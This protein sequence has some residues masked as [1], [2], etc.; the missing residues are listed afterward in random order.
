MEYYLSAGS[1]KRGPYSVAE[2]ATRGIEAETLVMASEGGQWQPAWQVEELRPIIRSQSD[3]I[4]PQPSVETGSYTNRQAEEPVVEGERVSEA[5]EVVQGYAP[6]TSAQPGGGSAVPPTSDRRSHKHFGGCLVAALVALVLLVG[7]LVAT[8][9][10]PEQHAAAVSNVVSGAVGDLLQSDSVSSDN[11]FGAALKSF[12]SGATSQVAGRVVGSAL[13]VDD[14]HVCSIG[15]I[16][17]DGKSHVVSVGVL[18][19][20]FTVGS[21]Y[22]KELANH[23]LQEA[24]RHLKLDVWGKVQENITDS[25]SRAVDNAVEG[26]IDRVAGELFGHSNSPDNPAQDDDPVEEDSI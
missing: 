23:Y 10:T 14:Y 9:P 15:R 5:Q 4:P 20:V 8:C 16:R 24:K 6:H 18:G 12:A 26:L 13:T 17:Y 1:E 19:H 25:L 11:P 21:A 7:L 3:A 22:L 2:L